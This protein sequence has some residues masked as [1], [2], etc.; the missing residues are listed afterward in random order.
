MI[1]SYW[2]RI[3][4]LVYNFHRFAV[5]IV[6][7]QTANF[8]YCFV[9]IFWFGSI[10]KTTLYNNM[11]NM[12][13][14]DLLKDELEFELA[15][16]GIVN[17]TTVS[18]MRKI[19]REI[20]SRERCGSSSIVLKAPSSS[21]VLP[22]AEIELCEK[23]F[24]LLRAD[25]DEVGS[26][27]GRHFTKR[28]TSRLVHLRNRIKLIL[29]IEQCH[30]KRCDALDINIKDA[31]RVLFKLSEKCIEDVEIS[32]NDKAILSE[33]L[34][35]EA[36]HI[37]EGLGGDPSDGYRSPTTQVH[38]A[39]R[40]Q[41]V[42]DRDVFM[43]RRSTMDVDLCS[44]KLVPVKDW[45][46]KFTGKGNISVNAFLERIIE[47]KDARNAT[48]DDLFRYAIDLFEE[49]ALVWFR[50][51]RDS[52]S[53]WGDLVNL[54][55]QSFQSPNYQDEL[56]DE[57]KKRTQSRQE[58]VVIYIAVMQNMFNRLPEKLDEHKKVNILIRNIQPYF[59]QALCRDRF[60][61][62]A[63]LTRVLRI[64]QQTKNNCD[65]FREPSSS[66][67]I[68]E[69]DLAFRGHGLEVNAMGLKHCEQNAPQS[70]VLGLRCWNCRNYGHVF[71]KCNVPRQRLFCFK[72]GRFGKSVK[73]CPCR[74]GNEDSKAITADRLS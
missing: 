10:F 55:V 45:G 23:K 16:R 56:L 21:V 71:R 46:V 66:S 17:I 48:Y 61:S 57:I 47:L 34:G 25:V 14:N 5:K 39:D 44:R 15:C 36:V 12:D 52:V 58:N 4:F 27:P 32:E 8:C 22:L 1:C 40:V 69:P 73:D 20:L 43:P 33:S 30:I 26:G 7:L 13:A 18:T 28:L 19:L 3:V 38:E 53:S 9:V 65:N 60:E 72:C 68:L 74:Q 70:T 6:L 31:F 62:V 50:S 59:Q 41:L 63:E 54:L 24:E 37:L 67:T 29:P 2:S 51:I 35:A 42:N 64:V 11:E 49:D